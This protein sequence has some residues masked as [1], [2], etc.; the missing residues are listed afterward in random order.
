MDARRSFLDEPVKPLPTLW[1]SAMDMLNRYRM[2]FIAKQFLDRLDKAFNANIKLIEANDAQTPRRH[3]YNSRR[4]ELAAHLSNVEHYPLYNELIERLLSSEATT[5]DGYKMLQGAILLRIH[6]KDVQRESS[7]FP[8]YQ[9]SLRVA[10]TVL[11]IV[12]GIITDD[13]L[14]AKLVIAAELHD[15][16]EDF[17]KRDGDHWIIEVF[18]DA[19]WH[20]VN[21]MTTPS[22]N[23]LAR[24]N[25]GIVSQYISRKELDEAFEEERNA[26]PADQK[27][28]GPEKYLKN[29]RNTNI[30]S[31]HKLKA[32][33]KI[34]FKLEQIQKF[35]LDEMLVKAVDNMDAV[36]SDCIDIADGSLTMYANE[37][38]GA[39]V[40]P[41][42]RKGSHTV[43]LSTAL[44]KFR[45]TDRIVYHEAILNR[46]DKLAIE[47]PQIADQIKKIQDR[48][49]DR[50]EHVTREYS[51]HIDRAVSAAN[52][53]AL[54]ANDSDYVTPSRGPWYAQYRVA[55]LDRQ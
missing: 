47:Q 48:L 55:A 44:A 37:N 53:A 15:D 41:G 5:E 9:H 21:L 23:V 28:K 52:A 43:Y 22:R 30:A 4:R 42:Q 54:P 17:A 20:S 6:A 39:D 31:Y 32:A 26:D 46:L 38:L 51:T 29:L 50:F 1:G 36:E 7:P 8:A 14:K 35:S 25:D 34:K 27:P 11:K 40:K 19:T 2:D 12:D 45:L 49:N 33:L 18:N 10:E 13:S 16:K 3:R 24:A